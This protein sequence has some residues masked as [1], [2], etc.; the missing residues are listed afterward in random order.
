M[1]IYYTIFNAIRN[2]F[3]PDADTPIDESYAL[4]SDEEVQAAQEEE[5]Q[6]LLAEAAKSAE[7]LEKVTAEALTLAQLVGQPRSTS[8]TSEELLAELD[9]RELTDS[10]FEALKDELRSEGLDI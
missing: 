4:I 1:N 2:F 10:E 8:M 5:L 6:D 9:D 3:A 7:E